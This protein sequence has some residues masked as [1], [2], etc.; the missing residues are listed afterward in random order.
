MRDAAPSLTS[1]LQEVTSQRR[2]LARANTLVNSRVGAVD[3]YL[4]DAEADITDEPNSRIHSASAPS[5]TA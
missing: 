5:R 2:I 1:V 3:P 4:A